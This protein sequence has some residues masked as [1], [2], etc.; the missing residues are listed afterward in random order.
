MAAI[1]KLSRTTPGHKPLLRAVARRK[2]HKHQPRPSPD[3]FAWAG[4][5]TPRR[6]IAPPFDP[7]KS[8]KFALGIWHASI[9][10]RHAVLC[11]RWCTSQNLNLPDDIDGD[12]LRFHPRLKHGN[13]RAPGL[14]WLL[15]DVFTDEP[16]AIQRLFLDQTGSVIGRRT[17]GR[18]KNAAVKL[19]ADENVTTGLVICADVV[20]AI[21]AMNAG[22]RPIW[23]VNSLADFPLIPAIEALTIITTPDDAD[24]LA[25]ASRWQS[26]GREVH[27][28]TN[29][30]PPQ[31]VR[32]CDGEFSVDHQEVL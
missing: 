24:A 27:I 25:V 20:N 31:V 14:I 23:F 13:D 4:V 8:V 30:K 28:I 2:L 21:A 32:P 1:R 17:L 12:V 5:F 6:N 29:E 16:V 18:T 3:L 9:D 26:A 10:A 22:L 19:D 11:E 15:R 7:R